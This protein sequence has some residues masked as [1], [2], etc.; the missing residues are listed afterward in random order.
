[1]K[2]AV[3]STGYD[4]NSHVSPL[5]GRSSAFV[6]ADIED[7]KIKTISIVE[8]SAKNETWCG[9]TAAYFIANHE[10]KALISGKLGPVAFQTLKNTG[11]KVYKAT[12]RSVERNLKLFME[13]KLEEITSLSCGF[14]VW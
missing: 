8:N 9:N 7:G 14:P 2:V 11:T 3:A 12:P 10:V 1:M 4:L 6:I 13:G 5:F